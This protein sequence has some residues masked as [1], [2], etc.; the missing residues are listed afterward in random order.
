MTIVQGR[1]ADPA[2]PDEVVATPVRPPL[3]HLHVGSQV[4]VGLISNSNA[5]G[6]YRTCGPHGCGDR[7]AQHPG[8]AGHVDSGRTGFLVG[9]PALAREFASCCASGMIVG[10]RL[11]GGSRYDIAVGRSTSS[12]SPPAP[13]SRR[14]DPSS[15]VYVTSAI[16]AQAQRAIRPEAVALAVFGLIAGLPR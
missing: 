11:D 5:G 10:L 15:I 14:A 1:A 7:G 9:T 12:C 2:R 16:E 13:T 3:L 6:R 8:S 4:R